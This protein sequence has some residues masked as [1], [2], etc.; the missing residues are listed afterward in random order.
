ML[1]DFGRMLLKRDIWDVSLLDIK[2]TRKIVRI[3][4]GT[5]TMKERNA[6]LKE[7]QKGTEFFVS[8]YFI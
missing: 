8:I 1:V 3:W 4:E 5:T 7:M 6:L 2:I